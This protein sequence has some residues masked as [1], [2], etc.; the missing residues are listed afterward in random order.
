MIWAGSLNRPHELEAEVGFYDTT[1]RDGEQTVGVVFSPDDKLEIARALSEA[2]VERIEAGFPRVSEDDYRA[3]ELIAGAGL[4]AEIWGFSRAVRAD[5]EA[6]VEL[7]DVKQR[8]RVG[9]RRVGFEVGRDR[10]VESARAFCAAGAHEVLVRDV[11]GLGSS[12][13]H[14]RDGDGRDARDRDPDP[15]TRRARGHDAIARRTSRRALRRR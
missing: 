4:A 8:V 12:R 2:G 13:E 11:D 6:L 5:V 3:V 10:V 15:A 9:A 7:G 1:L 14:D